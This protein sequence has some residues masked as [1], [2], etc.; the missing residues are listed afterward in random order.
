MTSNPAHTRAV[1]QLLLAAFCW[2]I[3]GLLIKWIA[4][5]PLAVAGGRG[6]LAALVLALFQRSLRFT[7]SPVQLGAALAYALTTLTFVTATKFTTAANAILLQYTAP[8]WVALLGA[9]LLNERATRTDWIA[10]G[11]TF[12]GMALFFA[13]S[14]QLSGL[15]G[16]FVGALSGICFAVM[17]MLMRKQK[18]GSVSESII[19]GN[20]IAAGIGLPFMLQAAPL[21]S[22]GWIALAV[23][24][25]VQLGLPYM[26]Y[27]RAIHHVT[28]LEAVLIPVI[29][30][31]L[32][33]VWV[34]L[35]LGERPGPLSLCGGV[36]VLAAVIWR[37]TN[38]IKSGY[39]AEPTGYS[40]SN[41]H[42]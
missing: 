13:D 28:A 26:L 6:L 21:D 25:V 34:M 19:L 39:S 30:P 27:A 38:S 11:V 31:I 9:S 36:L 2:S 1:G 17:A 16:N 35:F 24:G 32:N 4:W 18:G 15:F 42:P 20:L 37:A 29:E 7:W 5:P 12:A 33:P 23:L 41:P 3:G 22:S 8:V 40:G 14:L 10:I